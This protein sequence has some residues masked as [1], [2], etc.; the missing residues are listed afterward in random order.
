MIFIKITTKMSR[1]LF[2]FSEKV[3]KT[4]D[5]Q[6]YGKQ[7]DWKKEMLIIQAY[8]KDELAGVLELYM[9]AGVMHIQD[10]VVDFAQQKQGIGTALMNKAE[11]IAKQNNMHKIYL[12]T[13]KT[14]G[15]RK[16]Y[17]KLGFSLTG[18]L[19]KHY[20]KQDYVEYTK[21]LNL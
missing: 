16:F 15:V 19:P 14:W 3:W 9:Q 6:Y 17:E 11:E 18:E 5:V 1:K 12:E 8:N 10:L 4:A 13:G 20:A 21:L 2:S 7:I